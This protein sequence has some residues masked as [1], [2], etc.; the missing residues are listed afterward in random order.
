MEILVRLAGVQ[1]GPYSELEVRQHL[2]EGLLSLTDLAKHEGME[3]WSSVGEVLAKLLPPVDERLAATQ[4][5]G[6]SPVRAPEEVADARKM[7]PDTPPGVT[8]LP[9]RRQDSNPVADPSPVKKNVIGPAAPAVPSTGHAAPSK[10]V[11]SPLSA[12]DHATKKVSRT[13]LVKMLSQQTAP[14]PTKLIPPPI[15]PPS[16]QAPTP[17]APAIPEAPPS[18]ED[19]LT[20]KTVPMRTMQAPPL[21][22]STL[23][24]TAPL[25][26][27][28]GIKPAAPP[29]SVVDDFTKKLERAAPAEPAQ[30][31]QKSRESTAET[32][33]IAP[34]G[35]KA[36]EAPGALAPVEPG[37]EP[38]E[39]PP[40]KLKW[41][42][43]I[44]V[45]GAVAL[46]T[47]YYIWS[48]YHAAS[49]LQKALDDGDP[50][51][52]AAAI[53][54]PAVR[55]SLKQQ[56]QDQFTQ[57]GLGNAGG[58]SPAL[59]MLD[60]SIDRYITPE[61]FSALIKKSG[62]GSTDDQSQTVPP[63]VAAH[64]L[65]SY[66]TEPA[67]NRGLASLGDFVIDKD[68]A[69]LHLHFQVLGWKLERVDLAP[70][71]RMPSPS[72]AAAPLLSPVVDT[73]LERGDAKSKKNDWK[74]AIDDYT[75]VLAIDP[76]SAV[77]YSDRATARQSK[78][79]V[80]GAIEDYTRALS[81]DP[82]M[83][84]AYNGRGNAKAVRNDVNGAIADFTQAINLDPNLATA[85]DSRG[86][87]KTARDD[88]DGAISDFTQAITID[89]N[90]ASAYSDRGFARQANGNF[91]GAIADYTQALA[92]KP[93]AASAYYNRGL[94]RLSQGNL[95]AA[96]VDFNR[97]LVFDPKI[98][99][100]YYFRGNA[101]YATHD[102]DGAIA[103]F[104]QAVTLDPKHAL[105]FSNRGLARQAKGDTE[106]AMADYTQALAIDP[107]I[108]I[109][110]YNRALIEAQK[111]NLDGAIAD[112]TQAIYIDP[113]NAPAYYT[114]GFAKLT[115][116]NLDGALADLKQFCDLAP[117]DHN[118]DH[119]RLYLWLIAKAENSKADPDQELSDALENRW[120]SS[121]DDF[122]TKTGAFLLG[123]TAEA[124]YLASAASPDAKTDQ[125]QHCEAWYF[126]GMKRLLTGDPK[127]ATDAFHQCV[128]TG[129]KD[130]CEYILAQAEL[131]ALETVPSP[132]SPSA[133]M[134]TQS[135]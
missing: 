58:N 36:A 33:R 45:L 38:S 87:A 7:A 103:D 66:D 12:G 15:R 30:P 134:P 85:Y 82:Q 43:L 131:Q 18:S 111:N 128:A 4:P 98:A 104:T 39:P 63:D 124:D 74:G 20:A 114:R 102:V 126:A 95:E 22:R 80:G 23:P 61:G 118:S 96:I 76:Q 13:S 90:L 117:R 122:A 73:Y 62:Q 19:S 54:F 113:K 9:A 92:L 65:L 69:M 135:P 89:P 11:T 100:A 25:P 5:M 99:E 28:Q 21:S 105:A 60:Q 6:S 51:A 106:G 107:K 109:A 52:L 55:A 44:Y 68:G 112:S 83:A 119:A 48:P 56:V 86:N 41:L 91:D 75:Q 29:P 47:L 46:V 71:L 110:Y 130:Y 81:I 108:A 70:S 129:Q 40:P 16:S 59:S 97:A 84:V 10:I 115:K 32:A 79:D 53:D 17:P 3:D 37:E 88:L 133:T 78:G 2:S 35:T 57:P 120:N 26:T 77:A 123:R 34:Q 93:K 42:G 27:R 116:G 72:G 125:T 24:I 50:A 8:H 127:G 94:A 1:L 64:L 132:A 49:Q 121:P 14:L 31:H 67:R 101:K